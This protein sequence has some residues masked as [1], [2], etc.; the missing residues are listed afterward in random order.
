MPDIIEDS[1]HET[2]DTGPIIRTEPRRQQHVR[3]LDAGGPAPIWL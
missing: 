2:V 1:F 3:A